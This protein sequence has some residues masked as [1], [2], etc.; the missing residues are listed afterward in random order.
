V[1][2]SAIKICKQYANCFSFWEIYSSRPPNGVLPLDP[3]RDF[4]AHT[5]RATA[6]PDE[7]CLCAAWS[8][9]DSIIVIRYA[10]RGSDT[11]QRRRQKFSI[12]QSINQLVIKLVNGRF[13]A[14]RSMEVGLDCN[15]R[16]LEIKQR[17]K[18]TYN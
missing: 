5:P 4:C 16:Q 3:L 12:S 1:I 10:C 8:G 18:P 9:G 6:A 7:N 11:N 2:V 17:I 14:F 13:I 15:E